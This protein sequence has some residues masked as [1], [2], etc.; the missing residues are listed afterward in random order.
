MERSQPLERSSSS[1]PPLE[2]PLPAS[3][4]PSDP[5]GESPIFEELASA[6]FRDNW[7]VP[8]SG[9]GANGARLVPAPEV[10]A[11]PLPP[12]PAGGWGEDDG[13]NTGGQSLQ[14]FVE[15]PSAELTS[16][17]LPLR[18]RGSQL[19][20]GGGASSSDAEAPAGIS[21]PTRNADQVRGRLASYQQGVREGR[22]HRH[23]ADP[24]NLPDTSQDLSEEA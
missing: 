3:Q 24:A 20:P 4:A 14:P 22:Q 21:V 10:P 23:R 17:G 1:I 12:E 16:A 13:W 19:I 9:S 18:R 7:E 5:T 8:L 15:V 2:A 6:W 11:P